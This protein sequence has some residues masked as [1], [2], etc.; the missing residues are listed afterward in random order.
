MGTYNVNRSKQ[1]D[2]DNNL[3]GFYQKKDCYVY[4]G[5]NLGKEGNIK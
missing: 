4:I 5:S 1:G 2:N 3:L